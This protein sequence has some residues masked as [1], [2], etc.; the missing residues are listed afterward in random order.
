M[1]LQRLRTV[2]HKAEIHNN[3]G[4]QK[5]Q[6]KFIVDAPEPLE[7][8][9]TAFMQQEAP[10]L[11]AQ[12]KWD[13]IVA[14][15]QHV[16]SEGEWQR[17]I[18]GSSLFTYFSMTAILHKFPPAL[19]SDLSIFNKCRAMVIFDRMNSF[20]QLV[21]RN[22]LTSKHFVPND[23]P[24][25]TAALYSLCGVSSVTLNHWS[26]RPEENFEAF[27]SFFRGA[28]TDGVYLGAALRKYKA[29]PEEG[30]AKKAIYRLNSVTYGV[31]LLRIV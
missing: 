21:D 7:K 25:Q 16:P 5:D 22:V 6:L 10:K 31:P 18:S 8:D 11:N 14:K 9:S 19:V 13:G 23:Q 12:A 27:K 15:A 20:K 1:Y 28:L 2:G 4:V 17:I 30:E 3:Q 24:Y 26:L 29:A